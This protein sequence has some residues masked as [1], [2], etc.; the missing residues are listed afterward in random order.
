MFENLIS[1]VG[2]IYSVKAQE[3]ARAKHYAQRKQTGFVIDGTCERVPNDIL[4]LE[5][6]ND[7]R[8]NN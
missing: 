2:A 1:I 7:P 4:L 5:Y 3:Q 8:S 6:K